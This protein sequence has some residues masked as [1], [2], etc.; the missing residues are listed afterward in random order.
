MMTQ[1][2]KHI[3]INLWALCLCVCVLVPSSAPLLGES[4]N[5]SSTSILVSWYAPVELNGE[6]IEYAVVLQGPRGSNSTYTPNSQLTLTHL[7]PYTAYNLSIS[8]VTRKG[9]GPSLMLALQTDEAGEFPDCLWSFHSVS[10]DYGYDNKP[11]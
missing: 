4:R 5:L 3:N 6:I 7:T 8:A 1:L 2:N 9:I 10:V 11:V